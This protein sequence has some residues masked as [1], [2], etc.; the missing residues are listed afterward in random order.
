MR[1][2]TWLQL[3]ALAALCLGVAAL[4]VIA[5]HPTSDGSGRADAA[6]NAGLSGGVDAIT[7]SQPSAS[8]TLSA[9]TETSSTGTDAAPRFISAVPPV[10]L[11]TYP[12]SPTVQVAAN[13]CAVTGSG[14]T[15]L[16]TATTASCTYPPYSGALVG[17]V[18]AG[19]AMWQRGPDDC[20]YAMG[21]SAG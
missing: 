1:R 10:N 4:L 16:I 19:W 11:S 17:V 15:G 21:V 20:V 3:A 2:P 6:P 9:P 5:S 7:T 13:I 18:G 12:P 14:C 8:Q